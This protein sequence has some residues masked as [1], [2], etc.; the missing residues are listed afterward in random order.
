MSEEQKKRLN[1]LEKKPKRKKF[2][3][4]F[5]FGQQR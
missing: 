1:L 3:S 5:A 2:I 4:I